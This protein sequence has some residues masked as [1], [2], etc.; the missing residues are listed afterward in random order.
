[1][2]HRDVCY[3]QWTDNITN[4]LSPTTRTTPHSH[5]QKDHSPPPNLP[6]PTNEVR[7]LPVDVEHSCR[8]EEGVGGMDLPTA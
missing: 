2:V 7:T 4:S 1:M 3:L 5:P 6:V 8:G